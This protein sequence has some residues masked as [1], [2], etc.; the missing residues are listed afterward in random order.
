MP[1][2]THPFAADFGSEVSRCFGECGKL[3][4]CVASVQISSI[5][6]A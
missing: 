6:T 5:L 4:D 3:V 1:C 2:L